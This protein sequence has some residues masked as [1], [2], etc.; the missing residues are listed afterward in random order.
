LSTFDTNFALYKQS[1]FFHSEQTQRA[2][3]LLLVIS[4][5]PSIISNFKLKASVYFEQLYIN[6]LRARVSKNV[7]QHFLKYSKDSRRTISAD[8]SIVEIRFPMEFQTSSSLKLLS[9]PFDGGDKTQVVKN[10]RSQL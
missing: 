6:I 10:A 4:D 8:F 1:S 2:R 3:I 9:L 7:R 5:A